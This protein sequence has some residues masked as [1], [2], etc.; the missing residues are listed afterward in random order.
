MPKNNFSTL[1]IKAQD[2]DKIAYYDF[3]NQCTLFLRDRL[4][5]WIYR[6]EIREEIIQEI[7]IGVHK[8]LT[9]F[10]PDRDAYA[11]VMGIARFKV[12]DHLRKNPE[13]YQELTS[14]VTFH[15]EM[16]N[17]IY[18]SL[19][20]LPELVK[21][22]LLLTKVDG[23]STKEAAKSLGIKENALRTRVSRALALLKKELEN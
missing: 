15:Q 1:L 14:D 20:D 7:L 16:T 3:L 21:E 13:K 19:N 6:S 12:I 2:G 22:A 10:L 18:E 9:T 23:L 11:W 4:K 8:S 17:D 5:K